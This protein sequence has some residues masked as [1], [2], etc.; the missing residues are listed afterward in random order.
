MKFRIALIS[1][2][3]LV[4]AAC[5]STEDASTEAEADTVEIPANAALTGVEAAPVADPDANAAGDTASPA[6]SAAEAAAIEQ[7]GDDAA[8]TAAAAADAAQAVEDA[9]DS[10]A[11]A[12]DAVEAA[13]GTMA[14]GTTGN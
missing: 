5:G 10:A 6:D 12:A 8:A 13:A 11:G 7:A 2:A 14:E 1:A 9:A 4:L 3:T